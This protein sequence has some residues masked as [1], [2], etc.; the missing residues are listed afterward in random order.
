MSMFERTELLI[1]SSAHG[2]LRSKKVILFGL[3]GVGGYAGEALV[4]AGVGKIVAV[5]CGEIK[6]SNLNR[7]ILATKET[8]GRLKTEVFIERMRSINPDLDITVHRI[9]V[10]EA[11]ISGID[12]CADYCIDAIDTI[13]GKLAIIKACAANNIPVISCMGTGNKVDATGFRYADIFK[14]SVCPLAK[15]MRSELRKIGISALDVVYS[16]EEPKKTVIEEYGRHA[17]AS[18][19]YMPAIAGLMLAG[20]VIRRLS[21]IER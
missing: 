17:P 12:I 21:G 16:G 15:Q 18:I 3:G 7:Q 9:F 8:V 13:A 2:K 11:S 6:E 19:S 20:F 1:G 10:D 14:T 5:D 4:R